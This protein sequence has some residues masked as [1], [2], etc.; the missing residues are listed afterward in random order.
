MNA[1]NTANDIATRNQ[2]SNHPEPSDLGRAKESVAYARAGKELAQEYQQDKIGLGFFKR[3]EAGFT[4]MSRTSKRAEQIKENITQAETEV[5]AAAIDKT[6]RKEAADLQLVYSRIQPRWQRLASKV[7]VI[8]E[9]LLDPKVAAVI[10]GTGLVLYSGFQTGVIG[11]GIR[12]TTN[13]VAGLAGIAGSP[14]A[15]AAIGFVGGGLAGGATKAARERGKAI[16]KEYKAEA[17]LGHRVLSAIGK[18]ESLA[19]AQTLDTDQLRILSGVL[20]NALQGK[21]VSGDLDQALGLAVKLRLVQEAL[22]SEDQESSGAEGKRILTTLGQ[23]G[24]A[25][26]KVDE[27]I[28][29]SARVETKHIYKQM[30]S[31]KESSVRQK[32]LNSFWSGAK[33]G[34]VVGAAI[35]AVA[36]L[37]I[38]GG[39]AEAGKETAQEILGTDSELDTYETHLILM[40]ADSDSG[41][42]LI[43][44]ERLHTAFDDNHEISAGDIELSQAAYEKGYTFDDATLKIKDSTGAL[45]SAPDLDYIN[46]TLTATEDSGG[47]SGFGDNAIGGDFHA[48]TYPLSPEKYEDQEFSDFIKL[49]TQ[50]GDETAAR[51]QVLS[52]ANNHNLDLDDADLSQYFNDVSFIDYL[53]TN[54][55]TLNSLSRIQQWEIISHPEQAMAI[56]EQAQAL[57]PNELESI[58]DS[59]DTELARTSFLSLDKSQQLQM[60]LNP[61]SAPE[62][63]T[64]QAK[65]IGSSAEQAAESVEAAPAAEVFEQEPAP[66]TEVSEPE[67]DTPDPVEPPDGVNEAVV[68]NDKPEKTFWERTKNAPTSIKMIAGLGALEIGA[69]VYLVYIRK[70]NPDKY[71]QVIN[72]ASQTASRVREAI[73]RIIPSKTKTPNKINL[74]R[75]RKLE[76]SRRRLSGMPDH[77]IDWG[78][79]EYK[80]PIEGDEQEKPIEDNKNQEVIIAEN[81]KGG[82]KIISKINPNNNKHR[83][84]YDTE[85]NGIDP[86]TVEFDSI[87]FGKINPDST[88]YVVVGNIM[89][90]ETIVENNNIW[91]G[92]YFEVIDIN[93]TPDYHRTVALVSY[94]DNTYGVIYNGEKVGDR[95]KEKPD[96]V[97]F[98]N[99]NIIVKDPLDNILASISITNQPDNV[100][101]NEK[102]TEET[103]DAAKAGGSKAVIERYRVLS[104]INELDLE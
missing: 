42:S 17:W 28:I 51:E 9:K 6:C 37:A 74:L 15:G 92:D 44:S 1:D 73:S 40:G 75:A 26:D 85:L 81:K 97:E 27:A 95:L 63:L 104:A 14:I 50:A 72:K 36:G 10:A 96:Y 21:K 54:S 47:F 86:W 29:E 3:L 48:L 19:D 49:I 38:V 98:E 18:V 88:K 87:K 100:V 69:I 94:P 33:R 59:L 67:P 55:D 66:A 58:T 13:A 39:I 71:D 77:I 8:G 84:A 16:E 60:V 90:I 57:D 41:E 7:P 32:T 78:K 82:T 99:G 11:R 68:S 89:D 70:Y 22:I 31:E 23:I 103:D 5:L 20:T 53:H 80:E 65:D 93:F 30:L 24:Q 34:A 62:A 76:K 79:G 43:D 61:S 45:V 64:T 91:P 101:A 83:V 52:M 35:G 25:D 56:M 12:M 46:H 2:A 102:A 4:K